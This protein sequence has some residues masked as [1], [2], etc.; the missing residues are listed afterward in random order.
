MSISLGILWLSDVTA[1]RRA[2]YRMND[3]LQ[4]TGLTPSVPGDRPVVDSVKTVPHTIR[5]HVSR[6]LHR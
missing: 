1:R 3:L 6:W 5:R 4:R 2:L